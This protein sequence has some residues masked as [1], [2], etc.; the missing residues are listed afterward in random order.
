MESSRFIQISDQ[1]LIEY[2]YTSS[3]PSEA[4]TYNTLNFGVDLMRDANTKGTYFFNSEGLVPVAPDTISFNNDV[5]KSSASNNASRNQFVNLGPTGVAV[6]YNNTVATLTSDTDLPQV[7]SPNI[8]IEYD[9]VRIHFVAGFSFGDFDGIIFEVLAPR[10]D[11][12]MMN[13]NSINYLKGGPVELNP[14]PLLIAD[15]LYATFIEWKTPS[16]YY[17]DEAFNAAVPNGLAYRITEGKGFLG[18]PP[19]TLR[20]TGIFETIIDNGYSFYEMQSINSVSILNRDVYDNL[21]AQVIPST[22]GDYFELSGQVTGSSLSQFIAQ[23]NAQGNGD[24]IVF[25][26]I[27]VTEQ[28]GQV[29]A[30]SS[31][32]TFAQTSLFDDPILFRPII[33]N[34]NTAVSF[35]INFVLRLY[36]KGD[37]T[38]IIKNANLTS[39]NPQM[40]GA[41]MLTIN[42]G[43]VPTVAN[44]Y[45]QINNDTGKQIVVGTGSS[46]NNSANTS[47]QIVE[48]L[49]VKT[50]YVTT[51]RDKLN[52]K[53]SISPVK[54]QTLTDETVQRPTFGTA[55]NTKPNAGSVGS[56]PDTKTT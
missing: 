17:M 23:L 1:I 31:F 16:L 26:E 42:L 7:F 2:V 24:W 55:N 53:A 50:K 19:I 5:R 43:V 46:V 37:A 15:K 48:K 14:D 49:V 33:K 29:F 20:A 27:S 11:G 41:Q 51:F 36:N 9:T 40:Y 6:P 34:A 44:V 54:I 28:V 8:D 4:L 18:T 3:A 39:F 12:V 13:L 25:Y 30:Q 52:V 21:Y 47:E 10:T 45:N 38:Q 22:N 56:V 32:Q 35:S